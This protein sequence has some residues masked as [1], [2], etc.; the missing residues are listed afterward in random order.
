LKKLEFFCLS[1][2]HTS[3]G[4]PFD[5]DTLVIKDAGKI[6]ALMGLKANNRINL[7]CD[8]DRAIELREH[9][10]FII[11]GYHMNKQHWNTVIT[12]EGIE[13][14]LLKELIVHSYDLIVK[15]LSKKV[16]SELFSD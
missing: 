2:R 14:E 10:P 8:P 1:L 3:E 4:M 9:Y 15:S 11:P 13:D 16:Q 12:D 6:F 5:E 7:K